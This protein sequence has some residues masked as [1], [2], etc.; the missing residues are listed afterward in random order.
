MS[1][2]LKTEILKAIDLLAEYDHCFISPEGAQAIC[3]PFGMTPRTYV[4]QA[5]PSHP[6]G[7]TLNNGAKEA[8]GVAADDLAEQLCEFTA[9]PYASKFGRGSQLRECCR[10]LRE[11]FANINAGD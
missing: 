2:E 3:K 5:N 1:A 11:R 9:V 6:K 4:L 10:A 7:L 8:E